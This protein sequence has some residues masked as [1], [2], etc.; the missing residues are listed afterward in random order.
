[1]KVEFNDILK[2]EFTG[3]ADP[4]PDIQHACSRLSSA[5]SMTT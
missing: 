5:I 3:S 1:M 4:G 2:R